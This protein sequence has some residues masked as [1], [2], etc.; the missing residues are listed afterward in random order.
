[1]EWS[2]IAQIICHTGAGHGGKAEDALLWAV[3]CVG[4]SSMGASLVIGSLSLSIFFSYRDS[5]E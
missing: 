4:L 1:M 5:C 3:S 2:G